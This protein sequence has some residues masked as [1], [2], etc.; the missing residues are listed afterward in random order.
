MTT[1]SGIGFQAIDG[2]YHYP[3]HSLYRMSGASV[4]I[5]GCITT[6][7]VSGPGFSVISVNGIA[8]PTS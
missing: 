3:P 2:C 4:T 5:A 7:L 8:V 1:L 6:C